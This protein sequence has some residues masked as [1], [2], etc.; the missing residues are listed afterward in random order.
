MTFSITCDSL[1]V[2]AT[3]TANFTTSIAP[4]IEVSDPSRKLP[5]LYECALYQGTI[6]YSWPNIA[7]EYNN[8]VFTYN[9][10]SGN[11]H[12]TIPDGLYDLDDLN[13][14]IQ[15]IMKS[16]GDYDSAN[17]VYY[18]TIEGNDNTITCDITL[19]NGYS[20]DFTSGSLREI[21]G[22]NSEVLS[23]DGL[24]TSENIVDITRGV[25]SIQIH[26][27]IIT[28]NSAGGAY[29]YGGS[30]DVL[31]QF[32]PN[33]RPG[34]LIVLEPTNQLFY[35]IRFGQI[36]SVEIKITDQIG[37]PIDLRGENTNIVLQFRKIQD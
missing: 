34:S 1:A 10:G 36:D 30:T 11:V 24:H 6:W 16:N 27:S 32:I 18:I 22:F 13:A 31:Y 37:R 12:I 17:N 33:V 23:G 7:S 8:N 2:Q 14:Y 29:R 5:S 26:C 21:L 35:P 4:P 20:V 15:K 25:D 19:D 9:P 28:A 3:N